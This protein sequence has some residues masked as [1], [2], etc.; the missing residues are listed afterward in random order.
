MTPAESLKVVLN[1]G[2]LTLGSVGP[3][4]IYLYRDLMQ[5]AHVTRGR[6]L[7]RALHKRHPNGLGIIIVYRT[8]RYISE[9]M[10]ELRTEFIALMKEADELVKCV[11]VAIE[12]TGFL[13]ATI[14]ASAAGLSIIARP[15]FTIRYTATAHES[16]DWVAS[17]GPRMSATL[18]ASALATALSTMESLPTGALYG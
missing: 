1:D 10:N 13:G 15:K 7:H 8:P 11:G 9:H 18:D 4:C 12:Q 6:Q 5:L 14:R 2:T 3:V 17:Q 16:I